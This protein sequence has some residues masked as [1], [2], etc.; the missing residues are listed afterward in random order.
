MNVETILAEYAANNLSQGD[1]VT[2]EGTIRQVW[3]EKSGESQY[4]PWSLVPVLFGDATNAVRVTIMNPPSSVDL[5]SYKQQG[6]NLK[7]KAT[8]EPY[9]G[10]L[11]L[12]VNNL[13]EYLN[14]AASAPTQGDDDV[15]PAAAAPP[16]AQ[17][18]AVPTAE[19]APVTQVQPTPLST[20]ELCEVAVQLHMECYRKFIGDI[21]QGSAIPEGDET[22]YLFTESGLHA[23]TLFIELAKKGKLTEA[24]QELS[25]PF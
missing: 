3:E 6:V 11:Q 16:V 2:V 14:V 7:V 4:G 5:E 18:V 13:L 25:I 21:Y 17:P 19:A 22:T 23:R 20:K 9:N 1:T 15:T 24:Y 10:K 8:V 12:K